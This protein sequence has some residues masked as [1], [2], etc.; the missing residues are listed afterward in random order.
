VIVDCPPVLPVTDAVLS[1]TNM[2]ATLMIVSSGTTTAKDVSNALEVLGRVDAPVV[3]VVLNGV[4]I[5]AGYRYRYR[6]SYEPRH[7]VPADRA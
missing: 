2:D 3:G 7:T 1:A 6:Y 4:E 5:S